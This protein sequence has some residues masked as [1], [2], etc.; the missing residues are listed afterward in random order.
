[1]VDV[2]KNGAFIL[3]SLLS[4]LWVVSSWS[5]E[6]Q[7]QTPAI[8]IRDHA[9]E[10]TDR[11]VEDLERA[12]PAGVKPWLLIGETSQQSGLQRVHAFLPPDVT[13]P[14]LRRG[15]VFPLIKE[16]NTPWKILEGSQPP[17]NGAHAY[18]GSYAQVA[19]EGREFSHI[20]NENDRNRPFFVIGRFEDAELAGLI[21]FVRR[22]PSIPTRVG[23]PPIPVSALPILSVTRKADGS[24]EIWFRKG[25][26]SWA[27]ILLRPIENGWQFV[28]GGQAVA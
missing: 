7:R 20:E 28:Q 26:L 14:M 8:R 27:W 22:D 10:L 23:A 25:A 4:L 1:M 16:T 15:K 21:S 19:L 13:T 9:V 24:A 5:Q 3:L 6:T 17:G 2:R 18:S 11:D 12:L